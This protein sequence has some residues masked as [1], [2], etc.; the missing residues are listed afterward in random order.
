MERPSSYIIKW[1]TPQRIR[2]YYG[3]PED[4]PHIMMMVVYYL[5]REGRLPMLKAQAYMMELEQC[6]DMKEATQIVRRIEADANV[7]IDWEPL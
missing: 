7:K 5:W 4:F 6:R 1:I 2:I 3:D